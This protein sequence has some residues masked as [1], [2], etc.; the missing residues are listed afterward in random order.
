MTHTL[1][2]S[3][4]NFLIPLF[5]PLYDTNVSGVLLA[6]YGLPNEEY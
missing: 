1:D 3:L 4:Q 6:P 2:D 5:Q